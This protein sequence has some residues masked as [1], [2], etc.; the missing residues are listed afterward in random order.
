MLVQ[1]E[2]EA[3]DGQ[4]RHRGIC[5]VS[6]PHDA[7]R[8]AFPCPHEGLLS[9][10]EAGVAGW[11]SARCVG[12]I[13]ACVCREVLPSIAS[14]L[15]HVLT[16][17]SDIIKTSHVSDV[18][19]V[20]WAGR[21][22]VVK[23]Y[24]HSGLTHSLRHTIKG[25]RA[26]WGWINGQRLLKLGIR[27]PRPVAYMDEYRGPLLWQSWLITEYVD[28]PTLHSVLRDVSVPEGRKRRIIHQ[29]LRLVDRLGSRGINHGDMKHTNILCDD[30]MIVLTDLDG[31]E[32][33]EPGWFH[34][35]RRGRDI[36]RF[37]RG[38]AV[39]GEGTPRPAG[40]LESERTGR[41]LRMNGRFRN[42]ELEEALLAGPQA[43]AER[44]E[45]QPVRSAATS[46]VCRFAAI[47]NGVPTGVYLKEYL[48]RSIWDRLKHLVRPNRA[49]R[50]LRASQMLS[51][52]GFQAPEVI[53]VGS[54]RERAGR[55]CFTATLEVENAM[56]IHK[57]LSSSSNEPPP[58]SLRERREL[59]R[60]LGLTIGRMHR[61]GI[62]HGDLR[63]GN[64]LA[65]K[66]VPGS[67]FPV[68]GELPTVNGQPTWE[69]FL[70]DNERTYRPL[71]LWGFLRM[72]NLVQINMLPPDVSR[73]DR[74][75]FFHTYLLM[76]PRVRLDYRHWARRI[77][78]LTRDRF[79]RKG[80][81]VTR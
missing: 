21:D 2:S 31:V 32:I 80:W 73:T 52:H 45:S 63:P 23:R 58:C 81:S 70:L 61:E 16:S 53:A 39:P 55:V 44:F 1:N 79:L 30:G 28:K 27:T 47:F 19:R 66:T 49:V 20:Q 71:H 43:L 51:E 9:S 42:R 4:G 26:R 18:Y 12:W 77:M 14:F 33:R 67:H 11:C 68:N 62:V 57:Y 8:F 69:F 25:S 38:I 41:L 46:R 40:F 34:R 24:H 65:H 15:T 13:D 22:L 72:K 17:D 35:Q 37:L 7:K 29:V 5:K 76:N 54:R 64:V 50:A 6:D 59:L 78:T 48:D 75:R 60:R 74:L 56:P 10:F 36:A 3:R